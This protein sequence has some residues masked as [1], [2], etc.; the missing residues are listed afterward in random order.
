MKIIITGFEFGMAVGL[1][2]VGFGLV[3]AVTAAVINSVK[4][5]KKEKKNG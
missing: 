2:V 4:K 5:N 1:S 3:M